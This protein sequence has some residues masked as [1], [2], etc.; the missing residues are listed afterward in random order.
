[1]PSARSRLS[2]PACG[3]AVG[4]SWRR[5][6]DCGA[7]TGA[8]WRRALARATGRRGPALIDQE[9]AA[10]GRQRALVGKQGELDALRRDLAERRGGASQ[11]RRDTAFL[12]RAVGVVDGALE[13]ARRAETR[14]RDVAAEIAVARERFRLAALAAAVDEHLAAA[15]AAPAETRHI[16]LASGVH[17]FG[18]GA[19]FLA[20]SSYRTL[21]VDDLAGGR[22]RLAWQAD[23]D[24]PVSAL[25]FDPGGRWLAV[26]LAAQP[27]QVDARVVIHEA[28]TGQRIGELVASGTR[29][30]Y[31]RIGSLAFTAAGLAAVLVPVH[32]PFEPSLRLWSM[33][34]K[35]LATQTLRVLAGRLVASA[36]GSR[37]AVADGVGGIVL[38]RDRDLL[39][40]REVHAPSATP[41]AFVDR[42]AR[43]LFSHAGE[44]DDVLSVTDVDR[45]D[46]VRDVA[47]GGDRLAASADGSV[48]ATWAF[49]RMAIHCARTWH[50]LA[51]VR[52]PGPVRAAAI[53]GDGRSVLA[54]VEQPARKGER[55][56]F[57]MR[58]EWSRGRAEGLSCEL[59]H[60]A[61]RARER[62]GAVR[63]ADTFLREAVALGALVVRRRAAALDPT[64]P[65][66]DR[67]AELVLADA[68]GARAAGAGPVP[69]EIT[70]I[71]DELPA[72][73][74]A[75]RLAALGRV[76]AVAAAG[77]ADQARTTLE[78]CEAALRHTAEWAGHRELARSPVAAQVRRAAE[79]T[80]G[81]V[82]GLIDHAFVA[83]VPAAIGAGDAIT[84]AAHAERLRLEVHTLVDGIGEDAAAA[85][86]VDALVAGEDALTV[87]LVAAAEARRA[88][89]EELDRETGRQVAELAALRDVER[90]LT[91]GD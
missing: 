79:Q 63:D 19:G 47:R 89:L 13:E 8:W 28:A 87:E 53:S 85:L 72:A 76:I 2:C 62:A 52:W 12:D 30:A 70:R 54:V 80:L 37:L 16:G 23:L 41:L 49:D 24:R 22:S 32:G 4:P 81:L 82:Q 50:R 90:L 74:L 78:R 27:D 77:P 55:H 58:W 42:D 38:Y 31:G 20:R 86:E 26:A 25:A 45:P 5:C 3:F 84:D 39:R 9:D 56:D 17:A 40:L 7:A 44:R 83:R 43:L 68:V 51:D 61:R 66:D 88:L 64:D 6:P 15:T 60:T 75:S 29:D 36:D 59:R 71:L 67:R 14:F 35:L 34:G 69:A 1:V 21:A 65:A 18:P 57:L 11:A 10:A 33:A 91:A 73:V 48:V 46:R